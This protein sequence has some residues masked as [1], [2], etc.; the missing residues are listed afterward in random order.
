MS[1]AP[2][3]GQWG[4]LLLAALPGA[5]LALLKR[6][7][8]AGTLPQGA[9]CFDVA[10]VVGRVYF[11]T[12]GLIS[13]L[14]SAG[15]DELVEAGLI[16]SEGAAGLQS[17]FW[18]RPS[19]TRAVVQVPGEFWS[20]SAELLRQAVQMSDEAKALVSGYTEILWSEAQQLA[21]CNAIH[22]ALRR[23]ARWL[24]QAAD[25]SQSNQLPL[26]QKFLAEML[27]V[28]RTSL[29]ALAQRLQDRGIIK[30]TRG[31]IVIVDRATLEAT[32]C[33]CYPIIRQLYRSESETLGVARNM[34]LVRGTK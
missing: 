11:P 2:G 31:N 33:Q 28:R 21:A 15:G 29:T 30:Y 26:T 32:A 23:L 6:D 13:L 1:R 20:V 22:P 34:P 8:S 5:T 17:A 4:N 19:F 10:D 14:V 16:G 27:G 9:I 7:L 25:R 24:L 18:S 3:L 12:S